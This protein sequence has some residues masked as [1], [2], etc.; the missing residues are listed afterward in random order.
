M[1]HGGAG[2]ICAGTVWGTCTGAGSSLK[3]IWPMRE[4]SLEQK[5]LRRREQWSKKGTKQYKEAATMAPGACFIFCLAVGN[6]CKLQSKEGE[7][8]LGSREERCLQ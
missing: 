5:K 7:W 1:L 2:H 3:R 4:S 8:R 6:E